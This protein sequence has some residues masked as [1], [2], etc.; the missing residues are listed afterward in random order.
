MPV[1][2]QIPHPI[3]TL[4]DAVRIHLADF[5]RK[6]EDDFN[7]NWDRESSEVEYFKFQFARVVVSTRSNWKQQNLGFLR[8]RRLNRSLTEMVIEGP[9]GLIVGTDLFLDTEYVRFDDCDNDKEISQKKRKQRAVAI[10][11][12]FNSTHREVRQYVIQALQQD[13]FLELEEIKRPTSKP[14]MAANTPIRVFISYAHEDIES[15]IKLYEQLKAIDGVSPW[16][17]K[18]SLLPGIK[19]KPAIKKAIRE[20]D[21]FIALLSKHSTTKRGYVQTEMKEAF[22]IWE[23]FPDDQAYLIPIRLNECEP[24]Y[25]KLREVQFQDFF[26]SWNNG[27]QRLVRALNSA[28]RTRIND[29]V[30]PS[31]KGYEYRCAIVDLD[32]GLANLPQVCQKLNSIQNF[33]HFS[34]PSFD[35]EHTALREF[36]G[37]V[38]LYVPALPKPFYKQKA[39]FNADLATCLTKYLLAFKEGRRTYFDYL[40]LPSDVDDSFLFITTHGLYE[41]AKKVGCTF[42]KSVV[43]HILTQLLIHFASDLGFHTEVRGCILDFCDEHSWMMKGMKKMRLCANCLEGVGNEDLKKAVL[44]ILADPLKV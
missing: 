12:L 16:F 8:L 38:N 9:P 18:E 3:R 29:S 21:Y 22:E 34:Y 33:F 15:A 5:R 32:N 36:E 7:Y 17:D 41:I 23:Q 10:F 14:T 40:S 27:F 13:R 30:E 35:Y 25:E 39:L 28:A 43:Y 11:N 19:W 6:H 26:P 4:S 42:E 20:S 1:K 24:S 2:V 37:E 31:L 44:T